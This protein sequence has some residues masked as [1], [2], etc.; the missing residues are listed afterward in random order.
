[1]LFPKRTLPEWLRWSHGSFPRLVGF[2]EYFP[3]QPHPE[4][5]WR[6]VATP[7]FGIAS[8][9][10]FPLQ[11]ISVLRDPSGVLPGR[12]PIPVVDLDATAF[13]V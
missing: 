9:E 8:H 2:P 4:R 3:G 5:T 7:V 6:L 13:R 1:M 12:Q 10:F 11:H